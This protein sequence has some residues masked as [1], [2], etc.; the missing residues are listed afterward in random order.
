MTEP[1]INLRPS[2]RNPLRLPYLPL[3]RPAKPSSAR[4]SPTADPPKPARIQ[5]HRHFSTLITWINQRLIY[6]NQHLKETFIQVLR[7]FDAYTESR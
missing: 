6:P 7:D 5:E 4:T 3:P 1:L 2:Y